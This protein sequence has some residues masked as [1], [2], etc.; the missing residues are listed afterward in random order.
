[1][2]MFRARRLSGLVSLALCLATSAAAQTAA[3]KGPAVGQTIPAFSARDQFGRAQTLETLT[4]RNGLVL[5]FFRSAD[6]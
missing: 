3:P 1:M 2:R 5:L 6:W 4:G